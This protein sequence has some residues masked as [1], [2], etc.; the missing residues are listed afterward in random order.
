MPAKTSLLYDVFVLYQS[1]GTMLGRA[2]SPAP[3]NPEEYAIYSHVLEY[4][5][6]TPSEMA[7]DLNM[8]LQ[9]VSDWIAVL[10]NRG[11]LVS[12]TN[13]R[14]RRSY[15]ISLT[16]EG[17]RIQRE[18]NIHFERAYRLFIKSLGTP[19]REMRAYVQ[20]MT[21]AAKSATE[22]ITRSLLRGAG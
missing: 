11:H 13:D 5:R 16:E 8:P 21:G 1:V 18:T 4:N 20:E 3:L 6:C 9:T 22:T 19:E 12:T 7:R 2:L 17:R 10:R 14:D 15:R